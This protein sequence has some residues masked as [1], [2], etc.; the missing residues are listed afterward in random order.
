MLDIK[1]PNGILVLK[2]TGGSTL[3]WVGSSWTKE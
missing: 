2:G 3:G 1:V